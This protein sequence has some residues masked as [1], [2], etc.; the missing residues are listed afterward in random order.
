MKKE[1][2]KDFYKVNQKEYFRLF[3]DENRLVYDFEEWKIFYKWVGI[4]KKLNNLFENNPFISKLL[5]S[6]AYSNL[7]ADKNEFGYIGELNQ[8]SFDH[9]SSMQL[10]SDVCNVRGADTVTGII[11]FPYFRN[12]E[13]IK[14]WIDKVPEDNYSVYI[15][16][17]ILLF[18][19]VGT[20]GLFLTPKYYNGYY[21][22]LCN[23]YVIGLTGYPLFL[24]FSDE[25]TIDEIRFI[26]LGLCKDDFVEEIY[27]LSGNNKCLKKA[28]NFWKDNDEVRIPL[29]DENY[30][31]YLD[32]QPYLSPDTINFVRILSNKQFFLVHEDTK[33]KLGPFKE[34]SLDQMFKVID[35]ENG[36]F[37]LTE[38]QLN[39]LLDGKY[40]FI[41]ME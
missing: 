25:K 33:V 19:G 16:N 18:Y 22:E 8:F 27:E 11:T 34:F 3:K 10:R 1:L 12:W 13:E 38:K 14:D 21:I 7:I 40:D 31:D 15:I 37:K 6:P 23:R 26:D 36:E 30:E 5:L 29:I 35:T 39:C 2:L 20:V 9:T 41:I 17:P 4:N 24:T 32:V 28:L